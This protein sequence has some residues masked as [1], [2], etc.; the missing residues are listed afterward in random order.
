MSGVGQE[1]VMYLSL[2]HI[3]GEMPG[4][5]GAFWTMPANGSSMSNDNN[6]GSARDGTE[7]DIFETPFY[8]SDS[9]TQGYH[10]DGYGEVHRAR[11]LITEIKGLYGGYHTIGIKWTEDMYIMYVDGVETFRETD[12]N[13]VAQVEEYLKV[14]VEIGDWGGYM[15]YD[16]LPT[17][18]LTVDYV[19][20]YQA[21]N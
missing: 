19:R 1:S 7:I 20:A 4:F 15:D 10:Y 13:M 5:W 18:A 21:N 2:I 3:L 11:G 9:V 16:R 6:D 17:N 8:Q 12:P 14:T